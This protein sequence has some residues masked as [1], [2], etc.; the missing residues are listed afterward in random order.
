[1]SANPVQK[2]VLPQ[3]KESLKSLFLMVL[4]TSSMFICILFSFLGILFLSQGHTSVWIFAVL[5]G[6]WMLYDSPTP[7][8]GGTHRGIWIRKLSFWN[9]IG[10][11]FPVV[12]VDATESGLSPDR[13]YI[14]GHSPHGFY[15]FSAFFNLILGISGFDKM[16]PHLYV[17]CATLPIVFVVP[18]WREVQLLY[19][20]ISSE[21]RSCLSWLKFGKN[22]LDSRSREK[23]SETGKVLLLV[24]GGA[25][26][27]THIEPGTLDLVLIKRKGFIKLA[28]QTGS[29]VVPTLSFGE[30]EIYSTVPSPK[31]SLMWKLNRFTMNFFGFSLPIVLGRF[32]FLLPN[33]YPL[34]TIVGKPLE[35]PNPPQSNY[36]PERELIAEWHAKYCDAIQ[37]L[38]DR[39]K[40]IYAVKRKRDLRFVA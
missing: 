20:S 15:A 5:Y 30:N 27:A 19:G 24:L 6:T 39:Y 33:P 11:Y 4:F 25:E 26:E 34:V 35:I 29:Y 3:R 37:S 40:D 28:L 7:V 9:R 17:R 13:N 14:M 2:M 1:M 22:P 8:Q 38:Y 21:Y 23:S 32:L 16:F 18:F 12:L 10:E 36:I 31:G